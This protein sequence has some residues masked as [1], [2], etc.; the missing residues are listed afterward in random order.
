LVGILV[1]VQSS[2]V[3]MLVRQLL[4]FRR[5]AIADDKLPCAAVVLAIR[6]PDPYLE[7]SLQA[8]LRQR[9][10]Q[11]SVLIVVDHLGDPALATVNKV[12]RQTGSDRFRVLVLPR[13]LDTCT[14][15]CSS[16]I[17]AI[18]QLDPDCEVVAFIDGDVRPHDAWLRDLVL[19]VQD[20]AI[21]VATGNRWYMPDKPSWGSLVRYYWN[22]G[23]VG[24]M[25][26]NGMIWAGSMAL[27]VETI[28]RIA[29]RD[30]WVHALSVDATV[31]EQVHQHGLRVKFVPGVIMVNTENIALDRFS[32]WVRRQLVGAKNLGSGWLSV[33][34]H[35]MSLLAM[36]L[37]GVVLL[38]SG[39]LQRDWITAATAAA[40]LGLYWSA[41]LGAAGAMEFAVRHVARLNGQSFSWLRPWTLLK[42]FP[43]MVLTHF[44]Y[45]NDLLAACFCNKVSWRGIEYRIFGRHNIR[46]TS[47]RSYA[48]QT[49]QPPTS[50]V[51]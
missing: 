26:F 20:P 41:A 21:G 24:Q 27:R 17:H 36:Q 18:D 46:M 30:A 31:Y 47:Y 35:A 19:G 49:T 25:W 50:S 48:D 6:G 8:L 37:A 28:R 29:L 13:P 3:A 10:P 16:L 22:A 1:L 23:A 14:L 7:E 5:P 42:L 39:I 12:I 40:T 34:T 38:V 9:Y 51:I 4:Q 45:V 43:A 15:K 44:V 2:V 33:L 32:A 11:F